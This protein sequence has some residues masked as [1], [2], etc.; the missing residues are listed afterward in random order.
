MS[1]ALQCE[2][3][4]VRI[5]RDDVVA[6]RIDHL[7]RPIRRVIAVYV[8]CGNEHG[9]E[10]RAY[11][12]SAISRRC[13]CGRRLCFCRY[14]KPSTVLLVMSLCVSINRAERCTRITS[15]SVIFRVWAAA[16]Y[17]AATPMPSTA[18]PFQRIFI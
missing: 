3:K 1:S 13:W 10:L 14:R 8:V 15:S 16:K 11:A 12:A 6:H 9:E 4:V 2:L 7:Q 17:S 18:A 5:L